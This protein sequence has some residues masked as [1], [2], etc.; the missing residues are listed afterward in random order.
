MKDAVA[1]RKFEVG[2]RFAHVADVGAGYKAA[3][4]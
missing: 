1:A 4:V 2:S 3:F